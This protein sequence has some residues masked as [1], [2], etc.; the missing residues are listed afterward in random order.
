MQTLSQSQPSTTS[1]HPLTRIG[2][3]ELTVANLERS[4]Q[5]YTQVMGLHE[6]NRTGSSAVLGAGETALLILHEETGAKPQPRRSTGLYH[7]AILV[8]SREDLGHVLLNLVRHNVQLGGGD[9]YVSEAI[10]LNDVDGNGLE[11]YR[12]RPRSEWTWN[13]TQVNMGTVEL[14]FESILA[15]APDP[16]APFAGM[17][18]GTTIGHMHL[19]VGDI[20]RAQAF[21]HDA[22]GFDIVAHLP[23][24]LFVS[25]GGYHHHIGMNTWNSQNAPRAPEGSVGLRLFTILV[26]YVT[27]LNDIAARLITHNI[28]YEQTDAGLRVDDPWGNTLHIRVG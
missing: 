25:A 6:L 22:L 10:Y 27:A 24:A 11:I 16:N 14:D 12:D 17:P 3:V 20:P 8:P 13:G 28:A 7:I 19:K 9:H 15:A 5:F 23:S 1:I 26:A 2:S 21:Y 4:I 18:D